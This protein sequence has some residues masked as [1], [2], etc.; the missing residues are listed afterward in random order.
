MQ[1]I[2]E[3][4]RNYFA[5]SNTLNCTQEQGSEDYRSRFY[6]IEYLNE[7]CRDWEESAAYRKEYPPLVLSAEH[8][9]ISAVVIT[10]EPEGV[11]RQYRRYHLSKIWGDWRIQR[12]GWICMFCNGTGQENQ[13]VCSCCVGVGWRYYDAIEMEQ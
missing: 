11:G 5:E 12:K 1:T 3:F 2:Y 6:S 8:H 10:S 9:G 4:M 13:E 7:Q